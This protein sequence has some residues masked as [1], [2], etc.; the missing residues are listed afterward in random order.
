MTGVFETFVHTAL[1]EALGL[2]E[3]RFPRARRSNRLHLDHAHNIRL[4][5]DITWWDNATCVLIGDIK[6]KRTVTGDGKNAD[7][8]Q[9]LAYAKATQLDNATL[10][11]ANTESATATHRTP[12]GTALHIEALDLD[13]EPD[14]I[15]DEVNA[16][17]G[18][19]RQRCNYR[20]LSATA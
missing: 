4:E 3:R 1:R 8:Y 10:I 7:L 9:V 14:Q 16:I 17:A 18:R 12:D 20:T 2:S 5:P 6:Y 13:G 11:Y 19:L 15:L